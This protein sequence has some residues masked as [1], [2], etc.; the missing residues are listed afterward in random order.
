MNFTRELQYGM[1][2]DD[3]FYIKKILFDLGYYKN[4]RVTS[5]K[6]KTYGGDTRAA[7]K[8]FQ[9]VHDCEITGKIDQLTWDWII[10]A[11]TEEADN[12]EQNTNIDDSNLVVTIPS[13]ISSVAAS[14]IKKDLA[15]VSTIRQK[16]VV[17]ILKFAYDLNNPPPQYPI[18]LYIRGGNIYD[19]NG[20]VNT[21]SLAYVSTVY[22]ARF[23]SFVTDGREEYLIQAVKA[24]PGITGADCSGGIVGEC[25]KF[26]VTSSGFDATAN[27]LCSDTYSVGIDKSALKPGD[28]VGRSE[29][30]GMYVGGGYV[31][32]WIGGAY[33]CQL[34]VLNKRVV[35][36]L[37]E[38]RKQTFS[39]WTKFRDPKCY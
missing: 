15:K 26:K 2:G 30:I 21:I 7:V 19:K 5:I 6:S 39:S 33:G 36:N 27:S 12:L 8:Y 38:R 23:P 4:T 20:N 9:S 16:I 13:N 25:R 3:V 32:E 29:H 22:P 18:S 31:V 11:R 10:L 28:W 24:N 35:Y 34:T 17:D 37:M 14:A 1:S